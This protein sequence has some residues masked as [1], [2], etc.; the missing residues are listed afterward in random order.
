MK[1]I[2][3]ILAIALIAGTTPAEEDIMEKATFA[4]GCFW[5][6]ES[7]FRT[8]DGIVDARVGYVGGKTKNPT[9]REVCS[10]QTGH[11]EALEITF[12]PSVVSY[13]QLVELFWRM[14]NPTQVNRQGPDFGTQYRS[15]IFYHSPAQKETAEKSKAALASLGKW[16]KPI[17]TEIVPAAAF[18]RAEEYHQR[19][20]EKNNGPV[21]HFFE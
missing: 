15:S 7:T 4:A 17:A 10:G 1:L 5:G 12:D 8:I 14:H 21:C 19:Y 9:Y 20:S 6:V 16:K 2:L 18:W 11:A 3:P 13:K